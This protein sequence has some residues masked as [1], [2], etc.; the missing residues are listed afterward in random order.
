M[1]DS[2]FGVTDEGGEDRRSEASV[3]RARRGVRR[4]VVEFGGRVGAGARTATPYGILAFLTA[5]AVAPV[6]GAGLG[7]SE[8][9]TAALDQ[10]GGLGS[11][12]LADV[13]AGAA[14][15]MPAQGG[16][17]GDDRWRD[18]IAEALQPLLVGQD[19]RGHG[20]RTEVSQILREVGAVGVALAES[21]Q[22][23]EQLGR[24]VIRAL[25]ELGQGATEL[26]WM[27]TDALQALGELQAQLAAQGSQ[28][29]EQLDLVR[30]ILVLVQLLRQE[31]VT[32]VGTLPAPGPGSDR[33]GDQGP[34]AGTS[35]GQAGCPYPGLAS[36]E[37]GDAPWFHGRERLV[38]Q[39]I[40]R[41]AEQLGGAGPLVV[42]GVSG[43][44]KSSLLRAGV[45]PTLAA[46]A[47]DPSGS[48]AGLLRVEGRTASGPRGS[49][50]AAGSWPQ[51]VLT[52]GRTPLQELVARTAHLAGEPPLT[53]LAVLESIRQTPQD[54]AALATQAA[55][56][57]GD[58]TGRLVIVVDQFEELFTQC[59]DAAEREAFIT[60]VTHAGPALVALAVRADF[61]AEC[62]QVPALAR[63]LA[64]GP[65]VVGA[66][67]AEE[68]RRAVV[69]PALR[70]GL[71]VEPGLAELLLTDLGVGAAG[72]DPG[73][74][75]L[76]AHVLRE[77]WEGRR[78]GLLT[79][80]AY[81]ETGG[82]RDAIARTAEGI[83]DQLDDTGRVRLRAAMLRLVTVSE[84]RTVVRRRSKRGL[85]DADLVQRLVAERLVTAGDDYVEI[86]HEALLTSWPRLAGWVDDSR[87]KIVLRHRL[88]EA[89]R[90]W[91]EA[92]EDLDLLYRGSQLAGVRGWTPETVDL[93][94]RE[95]RFLHASNEA[96]EA[97]E[98]ARARTTRRLRRQV[99]GLAAALVL[100]LIT[101]IIVVY[102]ADQIRTREAQARSRQHATQSLAAT[103]GTDARR[104]ALQAW[105]DH[106]TVEA[107]GALLSAQ[108]HSRG[109]KLG[110]GPGG[111]AVATDP[112]GARVAVGYG[113]GRIELWNPDTL[114]QVGR[115][116]DTGISYHVRSVDFSD[117]GRFLAAGTAPGT[118][119]Q[120]LKAT[121]VWDT[122][123][124]RRLR[125]LPGLGFVTWRHRTGHLL[126]IY[127]DA[128]AHSRQD[129]QTLGEWD[130]VT[131]RQLSRIR[132]RTRATPYGLDV[133]PDGTRVA[134]SGF[135]G[136][137][138]VWQ[139]SDGRLLTTIGTPNAVSNN[140]ISATDVVFAADGSLVTN[141][142]KGGVHVWAVPSGRLLRDLYAPRLVT[143]GHLAAS[144][145]GS[146]CVTS[147][148]FF[149]CWHAASGEPLDNARASTGSP[150][151]LQGLAMSADGALT[152]GTGLDTVTVV[153]Q[154]SHSWFAHPRSVISARFDPTGTGVASGDADG[155]L[156]LWSPGNPTASFVERYPGLLHD[157]AYAPDGTLA[158][159]VDDGTVHLRD[160]S[161]RDHTIIDLGGD[162]VPDDVQFSPDGRLLAAVARARPGMGA[163]RHGLVLV[164]DIQRQQ[165]RQRLDTG[166]HEPHAL[167]FSA[168]GARLIAATSRVTIG[169][170]VERQ[171]LLRVWRTD[172]L[173]QEASYTAEHGTAFSLAG[174]PDNTIAVA[175]TDG[176]VEIRSLDDGKV[177][178][179]LSHPFTVRQ[180][181]Y[182][183]DGRTLA[184]SITDD[185]A[186][187]LWN[188]TTGTLIAQLAGHF[189]SPP[190][191]LAFSPNGK[192]LVSTGADNR[193]GIWHLEPDEA[194]SRICQS[195]PTTSGSA[196]A[197]LPKVCS[198]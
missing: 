65:V 61:Y 197:D 104:L 170:T 8:V 185:K 55:L 72:Y 42:V 106:H 39:V 34:G 143:T 110:T 57:A 174:G 59:E 118:P 76:L 7:T 171:N 167:T 111:T 94:V 156:R 19:E 60:A 101:T 96:A 181:T 136:V 66:M 62:A 134:V 164:W 18:A 103:D 25:S 5:S 155:T 160:R 116:L 137:A 17:S 192:E 119:A 100:A 53:A 140:G 95:Q 44:G 188:A 1:G 176:T 58:V 88:E 112:H 23:S 182:S 177:R 67:D 49:S 162:L 139:L 99:A 47:L 20:L 125:S 32:A 29:R 30:Q 169:T 154:T 14:Q 113:D 142:A 45:L 117:D 43:A 196:G 124:G 26:R 115:P 131:G 146:V 35:Q 87:A 105:Q 81:R 21:A 52:P 93:G 152:A 127:L 151:T 12:Y 141:D 31:L 16:R 168:D 78:D 36:F 132:L 193:M 9:A 2:G 135:D 71:E 85:L 166:A 190:N 83:Y 180:V 195:L 109:G 38:A 198:A 89:S 40:G 82:L 128:K 126:A 121:T 165:E 149:N 74:L 184:T 13:L 120:M 158:V 90:A 11:N 191:S 91:T 194:V 56:A 157:L 64:K 54:F 68:V 172:D 46:G 173:S 3:E 15:R 133:S 189:D 175:G 179:T 84:G 183:S 150:G 123:T 153:V 178:R 70:A 138:R 159:A 50:G 144:L 79:L 75:P 22:S 51:V 107:R 97:A 129:V 41:L 92:G 148:D 80:A 28:Q 77:V 37:S 186:I 147:P 102:Q 4:W 108:M 73:S 187:R 114:R 145:D 130:P 10:L 161:G 122:T 98:L 33:C 27:V 63:L 6:V 163:D 86:S 48:A 24:E 69:E